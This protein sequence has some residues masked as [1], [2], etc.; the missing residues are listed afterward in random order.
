MRQAV[1]ETGTKLMAANHFAG[2]QIE[3]RSGDLAMQWKELRSLSSVR[4]GSKFVVVL[5]VGL[6]VWYM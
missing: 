1:T 4:C 6:D 5:L 3:A 2:P